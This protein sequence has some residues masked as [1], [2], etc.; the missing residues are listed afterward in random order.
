MSGAG[1]D[2]AAGPGPAGP[3][4]AGPG[5][6]G[7][8][9]DRLSRRR[10]LALAASAAV[11]WQVAPWPDRVAGA[12]TRASPG[13]DP[14]AG[15]P[16]LA[17]GSD[18]LVVSSLEAFAD[19]LIPGAK[20]WPGDRAVAGA[21][22][23]PGAVQAGAVAMMAFPPAGIAPLLPGVV[24]LLDTEAETWALANGAGLDGLVPPLVALDYHQRTAFLLSLL[25]PSSPAYIVWFALAAM[26]FLAFHTAGYL[27]T[28]DAVRQ[29]HPGLRAIGFPAP[30][31]DGLWRFPVFSYRRRLAEPSPRTA[32]SGSP[33]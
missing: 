16:G 14:T 1:D 18:G 29:H 11:A 26:V 19:T 32:P 31:P 27:P 7:G 25:D 30:D 13:P 5:S 9:P 23:G 21:A 12:L 4:P 8:G 22:P 10:L 3:G 15:P 2:R 24:A 17:P 28:V 20:R 33:S 6:S